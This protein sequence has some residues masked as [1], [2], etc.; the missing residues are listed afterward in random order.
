M[1]AIF[2]LVVL[3]C[4]DL[5][6]SLASCEG[7]VLHAVLKLNAL[8]IS[9][10]DIVAES[11]PILSEL[12][13]DVVRQLVLGDLSLD[14]VV[15]FAFLCISLLLA[16]WAVFIIKSEH[17]VVGPAI[18]LNWEDRSL[19]WQCLQAHLIN[20]WREVEAIN[21]WH[22]VVLLACFK[23]VVVLSRGI[24][25]E[26]HCLSTEDSGIIPRCLDVKLRN[27]IQLVHEGVAA[28]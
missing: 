8:S 11:I 9:P 1:Q 18:H 19:E 16:F 28:R 12:S 24:K 15:D 23:F 14:E 27:I 21:W 26:K 5:A 13:I 25:T 7:S 2:D 20:P 6:A 4:L 10:C 22:S 17:V 3:L